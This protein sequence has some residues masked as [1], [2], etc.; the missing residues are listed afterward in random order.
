MNRF[1]V[2]GNGRLVH[3]SKLTASGFDLLVDGAHGPHGTENGGLIVA[4]LYDNPVPEGPVKKALN[5]WSSPVVEQVQ[6]IS[7]FQIISEDGNAGCSRVAS[8]GCDS[9]F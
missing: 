3:C 9:S 8:Q 2:R 7:D 6:D 4:E 5:S 1:A